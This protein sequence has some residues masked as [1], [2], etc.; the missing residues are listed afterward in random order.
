MDA[1]HSVPSVSVPPQPRIK[2]HTLIIKKGLQ[3]K[4]IFLVLTSVVLAICLIGW[5]LYYT[6]GRDIVRDLMDPGL[7]ELFQ[8]TNKVLAAKLVIYLAVVA[9][10][11]VFISHRLA[12]PVYRFERS[13][14]SV[15]A[16][17]LTHR[18]H[19]RRGDELVDLQDEFNAMVESLQG[20]VAKDRHLAQRVSHQLEEILQ[21]KDVPP[22]VL[23]RLRELKAEVDHLT[24]EFKI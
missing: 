24:Q 2:R 19:L 14:R 7:Y 8:E 17:D 1:S 6:F 5:D 23:G 16:G 3:A 10:V 21:A 20:R 11:T 4:F 22:Q 12:G 9:I 13:A 18:V 15:G